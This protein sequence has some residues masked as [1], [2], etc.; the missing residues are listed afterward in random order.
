MDRI[1]AEVNGLQ[2]LVTNLMSY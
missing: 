1:S 2:S